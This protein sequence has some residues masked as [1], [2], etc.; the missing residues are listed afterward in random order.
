MHDNVFFIV[1][2]FITSTIS[3]NSVLYYSSHVFNYTNKII[4]NDECYKGAISF[5]NVQHISTVKHLHNYTNSTQ[6]YPMF[7]C[8]VIYS[9]V[10]DGD[11]QKEFSVESLE[12]LYCILKSNKRQYKLWLK[13]QSKEFLP[14]DT[15]SPL[16]YVA[17]K[18]DYYNVFI[19]LTLL[20]SSI[21]IL[22]YF[23]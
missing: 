13:P 21:L 8:F 4:K 6:K 17:T 14:Q 15:S 3:L 9:I 23:F 12:P 2:V 11:I 5:S 18:H 7:F 19:S 1:L 10:P 22:L 16:F 20:I